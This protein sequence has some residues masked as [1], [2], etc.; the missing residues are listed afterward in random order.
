MMNQMFKCFDRFV[1]RFPNYN[2]TQQL[3]YWIKCLSSKLVNN[4]KSGYQMNYSGKVNLVCGKVNFLYALSPWKYDLRK[5]VDGCDCMV[6]TSTLY[7]PMS[8]LY[9]P[10]STLYLPMSTLYPTYVYIIP[11]YVYIIPY[12]CLHYTLPM[13]TLYLPMSTLYLPMSTLY[14]T[15]VYIIP[16][17]VYI[18]PTYVYIIPYLCLSLI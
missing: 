13:S 3:Y 6:V 18:I 11:T 15:Y 4:I 5:N 9:L 17:Y 10:M 1:Q 16:T 2:C 14:P 8:T 12:L 7:L